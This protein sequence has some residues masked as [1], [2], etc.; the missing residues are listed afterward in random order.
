MAQGKGFVLRIGTSLTVVIVCGQM[1]SLEKQC[2]RSWELRW[3]LSL[4]QS[5][6]FA[7]RAWKGET[8]MFFQKN[9]AG[10]L[11]WRYAIS[12]ETMDPWPSLK[13]SL[14]PRVAAKQLATNLDWR[15]LKEETRASVA[16]QKSMPQSGFVGGVLKK[17]PAEDTVI[18]QFQEENRHHPLLFHLDLLRIRNQLCL[19]H[20]I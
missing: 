1:V 19:T 10:V 7:W 13:W 16:V 2:S 12:V 18:F 4:S 11:P 5:V 15:S 9:L 17:K 14:V 20:L 3:K 8:E 6:Y